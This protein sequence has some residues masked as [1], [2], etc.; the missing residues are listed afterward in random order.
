[1]QLCFGFYGSHFCAYKF[2]DFFY[3]D[4]CFCSVAKSSLT[5]FPETAA[6]QA[7]LSSTI[8]WSLLK[9]MSVDL[10]LP[11]S[12]L[13]L[14]CPLLLPSIFPSMRVLS[15]ELA[16]CI[17]WP[18][19]WSCSNSPFSQYLGLISFRIDW[20]DLLAVQGTHKSLRQHH[21]FESIHYCCHD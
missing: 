9:L 18:K 19:Y 16:L 13:I 20:F 4:C 2:T 7:S 21:N 10:V 11:P 15:N 5:L 14:C 12:Q 3:S 17:R 8:S 6:H 1:M